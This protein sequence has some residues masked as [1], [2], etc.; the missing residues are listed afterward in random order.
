MLAT[1]A[2]ESCR[3]GRI[4]PTTSSDQRAHRRVECFLVSDHRERVPVWVFKPADATEASAGLVVNFSDG[5]LQ[6]LTGSDGPLE[7]GAYEIQLLLGEDES[8]ARFHG[9]VTRVWT[10][11]SSGAGWLSGLRFDDDHSSAEDFI[12]VYRTSTIEK[13]WVRCLLIPRS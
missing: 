8:V 9:R 13:P 7:H 10:R 2:L 4:V 12:R 1:R 3:K 6:V 5:G 11:E